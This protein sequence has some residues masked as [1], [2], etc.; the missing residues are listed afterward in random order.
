VDVWSLVAV[1]A[2]EVE[3][4]WTWNPWNGRHRPFTLCLERHVAVT[5]NGNLQPF[6]PDAMYDE[7]RACGRWDIAP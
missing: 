6:E 2:V 4:E 7:I 3:A 5:P 1:K